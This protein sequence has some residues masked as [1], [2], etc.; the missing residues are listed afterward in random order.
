M[1][2]WTVYSN[3]P[4]NNHYQDNLYEPPI[5]HSSPACILCSHHM[6]SNR[7]SLSQ[8][9]GNEKGK[10][11]LRKN[12]SMYTADTT[13]FYV[14]LL[15]SEVLRNSSVKWQSNASTAHICWMNDTSLPPE[16]Y[17]ISINPKQM[18]I[19]SS[20]ERG[21]VYAVQT[22]RQWVSGPAG[23]LT[24][25]CADITDSPVCNG[26]VLCWILD[27]STNGYPPS[28]STSTWLPCLK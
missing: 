25:A 10:L 19:T 7:L 20:G 11:T 21:F 26:A 1:P 23:K 16:G 13:A 6:R 24:F 9:S 8:P 12:I 18:T 4:T 14:S 2:L 3:L 5:I 17:K 15:R 27:A 28:K 22:L